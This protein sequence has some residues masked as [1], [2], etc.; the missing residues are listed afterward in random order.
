MEQLVREMQKDPVWDRVR[1]DFRGAVLLARSSPDAGKILARLVQS[2]P[3]RPAWMTA[4]VRNDPW[5]EE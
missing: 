3:K 4:L 1:A 5:L 2:L